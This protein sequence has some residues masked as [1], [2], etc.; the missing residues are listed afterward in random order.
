MLNINYTCSCACLFYA[1]SIHDAEYLVS[2][3]SMHQSECMPGDSHVIYIYISLERFGSL[4]SYFIY[5]QMYFH[6][7]QAPRISNCSNAQLN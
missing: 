1:P 4:N 3:L 2:P 5:R 6:E 7:I